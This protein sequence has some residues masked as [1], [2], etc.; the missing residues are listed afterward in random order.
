MLTNGSSGIVR[1][2]CPDRS[3]EVGALNI[4]DLIG[5]ALTGHP[6]RT[7]LQRSGTDWTFRDLAEI[8]AGGARIIADKQA[9]HLVYVGVGSPAF[10][11]ATF[12][13]GYGWVTFT[14]LN[15]R[16]STT[17]LDDL[18]ARLDAPLVLADPEALADARF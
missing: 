5:H 3:S 16:R 9:G 11:V 17:Q 2:R 8:A 18:V 12:A 10:P 7:A 6:D 4:A 15:Y 14:P 13:A 1:C